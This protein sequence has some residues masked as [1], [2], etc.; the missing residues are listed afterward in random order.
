[1]SYRIRVHETK[2]DTKGS[3]NGCR[4]ATAEEADRAGSE[5]G[6]RWF[7]FSH[8]AVEECDD[9][10][11]YEFPGDISRPRPIGSAS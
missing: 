8:Y 11:N 6:S 2:N 5:L 10:P 9:P 3:V 7:G 1:M 4:F